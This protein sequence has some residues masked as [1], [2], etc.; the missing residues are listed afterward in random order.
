M[1]RH[2]S[3]TIVRH[4]TV[5]ELTKRI[6][7][8]EKDVKILQRLYLIK[9]RYEGLSVEKVAKRV[10]ISKPVAYIWQNRWNKA[11]Y[12]GL[13]PKFAGGKPSKLSIQQKEQLKRILKKQN[14]WTTEE[15]RELVLRE[16]KVRYTQ[17]QIRVILKSFK[18]HHAKPFPHDYRKPD[19]AEER[20][21]KTFLN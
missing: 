3:I 19:D 9:F 20:L 5:E 18:M 14:N 4:M 17:K 13:K 21:K 15:V 6:K 1:T 16:F 11:G 8:I 7:S 10:E 2:E 12:D